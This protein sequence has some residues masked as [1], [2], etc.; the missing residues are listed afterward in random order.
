MGQHRR[1]WGGMLDYGIRGVLGPGTKEGLSQAHTF[2][3]DY[4]NDT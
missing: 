2:C 4:N 1:Y 3:N